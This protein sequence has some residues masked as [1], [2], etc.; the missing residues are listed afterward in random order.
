MALFK[1][2]KPG[3]SP[4]ERAPAV[5]ID[6]CAYDPAARQLR[7]ALEQRNWPWAR[8]FLNTVTDPDDR[9]FYLSICADVPG[10]QDWIEQ[11]VAAE[12]HSTLPLL[13]RGAHAVYWAWEA[14][15]A[16]RAEQTSSDQFQDFFGRLKL[17][18]NCLDEVVERDPDDT[19]AWTFLI[20]SARGRQVD[21]EDA[22]RRFTGVIRRHPTHRIAHLQM[23]QYLCKKWFGSHEEMFTFAREVVA[24]APAGSPL[25]Q[26]VASAHIEMWLDL[27]SGEDRD[28]MTRPDVRADLN[29]AA[30]HTIR[31]PAY[32]PRPGWPQ[33]HNTFAFAF[34]LSGDRRAAVQQFEIIGNR[35]TEGPW[36]YYRR[37]PGT[38]FLELRRFAYDQG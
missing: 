24:K 14:R 9:A 26:L 13:V 19:T 36:D 31:H 23:L 37:D 15:G 29:A 6:P 17:A 4:A 2:R 28:Y 1:R 18:E 12:R 33:V 11:W 22:Q 10:V 25:G 3:E 27:P 35:V 30:D 38:A 32:R 8:D 21:R 20:T 7:M 34:A 5:V 16:A